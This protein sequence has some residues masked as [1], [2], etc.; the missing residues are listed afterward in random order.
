M[1]NTRS[2]TLSA[3]TLTAAVIIAFLS[4]R[5]AHA[6]NMAGMDHRAM[7]SLSAADLAHVRAVAKRLSN[8]DSA[9]AAGYRPVGPMCVSDSAMGGMG[10]H[11]FNKAQFDVGLNPEKPAFLVFE[12]MD[13][14]KMTLTAV[15]YAV[16]FTV[17]PQDSTPPKIFGHDLIKMDPYKYWFLHIWAVKDNPSGMFANY[18]P[19]VKCRT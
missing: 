5:T 9:T 19:T 1:R 14:G 11:A 10:Y 3:T 7:T 13:D 12:K 17:W 15:E 8:P 4:A 2:A 6:Q 16:P 18:S